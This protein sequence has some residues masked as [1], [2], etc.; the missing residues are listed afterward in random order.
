MDKPIASLA[1]QLAASYKLKAANSVHLVTAVHVDTD[2]FITNNRRDF[3]NQHII[4]ITVQY[5]EGL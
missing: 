4:E 5:P 2:R 1:A 3:D